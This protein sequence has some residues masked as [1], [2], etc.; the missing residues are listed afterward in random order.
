MNDELNE[1]IEQT[2]E[3]EQVEEAEL[4]DAEE[5]TEPEVPFSGRGPRKPRKAQEDGLVG[6]RKGYDSLRVHPT[7]VDDHISLGWV[8]A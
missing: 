5:I 3:V 8:E 1:E 6:M 7:C 2:E 4:V